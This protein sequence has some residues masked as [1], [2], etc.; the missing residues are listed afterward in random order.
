LPFVAIDL[1]TDTHRA[2]NRARITPCGLAIAV[3]IRLF[4]ERKFAVAQAQARAAQPVSAP[5][6]PP[7]PVLTAVD[8]PKALHVLSIFLLHQIRVCHTH[9]LFH[10]FRRTAALR[11]VPTTDWLLPAA[12]RRS[13][14]I[15]SRLCPN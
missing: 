5:N 13:T 4:A 9:T 14:I 1:R 7:A 11:T 3:L 8:H 10:R 2:W 12:R 15:E 6:D